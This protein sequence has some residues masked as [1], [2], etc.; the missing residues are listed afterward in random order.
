MLL[1]QVTEAHTDSGAFLYQACQVRLKLIDDPHFRASP[2]EAT[3]ALMCDSYIQGFTD[4][5]FS[6]S[7]EFC[8]RAVT[9]E[10]AIRKYVSF[11]TET[12][13]FLKEDKLIGVSLV[14]RSLYRCEK[15]HT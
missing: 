13:L 1:A 14:L 9:R 15:A 6:S 2:R 5:M 3:D 4:G 12:P 10:Q 7:Q 11:M 8:T